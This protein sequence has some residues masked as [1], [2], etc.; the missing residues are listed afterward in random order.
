MNRVRW[1]VLSLFALVVSWSLSMPLFSGPDEPANFVRSAAVVRGEFV[2]ADAGVSLEKSYWTTT[3]NIN[4]QF[5]VANLVPWCF[6]PF[7]E[8]P[9]CNLAI[10]DAAFVDNPPYTNMGRYPIF[11]FVVSGVGTIFGAND[12]SAL[13]SRLT[14]GGLSVA[15]LGFAFSSVAHRRESVPALLMAV[16]PGVIF[17][18]AVMNPSALEIAS[19]IALW[20]IL[21]H[22][23]DSSPLTKIELSGMAAAGVVLIATRP[24]GPAM[25]LVALLFCCAV[26]GGWARLGDVWRRLRSVWVLHLAVI[27]LA[28]G[29]YVTVFSKNTGSPV[30]EGSESLGLRQQVIE[31]VQHIPLVLEQGIGNFGWLD[32]PMPR[33]A[34]ILYWV[35]L[36]CLLVFAVVRS[37]LLTTS[38]VVS[39]CL[40]SALLVVA[41]DINYYNLLRNFG[42]QGRH[43]MPLLVGIPIL[44]LRKVKLPNRANAV[45]VAAWAIIMVWSG[46]AALRRYAVGIQP[47]NHFEMYTQAIWHPDIGI[48]LATFAL[49]FGGIASAW[50]AWRISVTANDH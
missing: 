25:Y 30:T 39:L 23:F 49:A 3:V 50:C 46:L 7:S 19:A 17:L 45:V 37:T 12:L 40:A 26:T 38:M 41:Q 36:I 6:A 21:P 18:S 24:L 13:V 16:T 48:W 4:P 35:M 32:T 11:P 29:W 15:L 28:V 33:I 42:S 34:L 20:T 5:G 1:L 31:A 8:K 10:E 2:G 44:A 47:G 22:V 14:L 43:V 9:A 27:A